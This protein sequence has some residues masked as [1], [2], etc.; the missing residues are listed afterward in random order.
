MYKKILSLI[1]MFTMLL[2]SVPV[3]AFE[4]AFTDDI[5][6]DPGIEDFL[7]LPGK[8]FKN[9]PGQQY[10]QSNQNNQ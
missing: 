2:T 7:F 1:L 9:N 3:H 6:G 4:D 5:T 10:F 8:R